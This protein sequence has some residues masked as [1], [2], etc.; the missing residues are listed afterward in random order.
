VANTWRVDNHQPMRISRLLLTIAV[1]T[2]V[3]TAP[4]PATAATSFPRID[5][6]GMQLVTGD[7][8]ATYGGRIA[9]LEQ[10][11]S[12]AP[13]GVSIAAATWHNGD[14]SAIRVSFLDLATS[15]YRHVLLVEPT[16]HL[17]R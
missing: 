3:C 6:T 17:G 2:G 12:L 15:K 7:T 10:K 1:V 5:A 11:P 16:H 9:A 4:V 13:V 8:F 14:D